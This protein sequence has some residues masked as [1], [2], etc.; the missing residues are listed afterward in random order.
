M[1]KAQIIKSVSKKTKLTQK[2]CLLCLKALK[3]IMLD[4]LAKGEAV[5]FSG[6][7]RFY[8]K[9]YNSRNAFNP[10]TKEIGALKA[11]KLPVFRVS[12]AIKGKI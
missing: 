10:K 4:V 5:S 1:N 8:V 11:R 12:S 2:D 7:G 3:E 6:F 9:H